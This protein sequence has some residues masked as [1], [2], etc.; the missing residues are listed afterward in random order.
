M[1]V[2][3]NK[4]KSIRCMNVITTPGPC[5]R[6][7]VSIWGALVTKGSRRPIGSFSQSRAPVLLGACVARCPTAYH[8]KEYAAMLGVA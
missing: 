8:C 3:T 7:F 2:G 6:K 5:H 4:L 1:C